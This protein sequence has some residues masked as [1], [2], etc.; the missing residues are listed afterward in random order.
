MPIQILSVEVPTDSK[1]RCSMFT[2]KSLDSNWVET[3]GRNR[4]N[5]SSDEQS[6]LKPK[7]QWETG[8]YL[9]INTL[10]LTIGSII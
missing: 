7:Q 10:Q 8:N 1:L 6:E 9:I 5:S 2:L 3:R 4:I